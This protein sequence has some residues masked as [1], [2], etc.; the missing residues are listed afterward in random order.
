MEAFLSRSVN[1]GFSEVKKKE[2]IL[3]MALLAQDSNIR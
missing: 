3:Q 1:Q 2:K